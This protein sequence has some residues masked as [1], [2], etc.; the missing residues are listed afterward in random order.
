M[1][2]RDSHRAG[3]AP[4][5][6]DRARLARVGGARGPRP[7]GGGAARAAERD[8]ERESDV[9][10]FEGRMLSEG[11]KAKTAAQMFK[12]LTAT[13]AMRTFAAWARYARKARDDAQAEA[14]VAARL[15]MERERE[16]LLRAQHD[17]RAALDAQMA[18]VMSRQVGAHTPHVACSRR[19]AAPA[20]SL[21]HI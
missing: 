13:I 2:I 5:A 19:H 15:E 16:Q 17:A 8:R 6:R 9:L 3:R 4:A 21:I 14:E 11:Q 7:T 12:R 18:N 1:C 20:L 10:G